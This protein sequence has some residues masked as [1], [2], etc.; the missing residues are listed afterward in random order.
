MRR[1]R[2]QRRVRLRA[3]QPRDVIHHLD[4]RNLPAFA[5]LRSLRHLDLQLAGGEQIRRRHAE[6]RRRHLLG[7]AVAPIAGA[8]LFIALRILTAFAAVAA[9]ADAVHRFGQRAMRFRTQRAHRHG[10][11]KEARPDS[12][13]RLDLVDRDWRLRRE[14][15]QIANRHRRTVVHQRRELRVGVRLLLFDRMVELLHQRRV[16]R[17]VIAVAAEPVEARMRQQIARHARG[18]AVPAHALRGDFLE[19][20][21]AG[22]CRPC[23]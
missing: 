23:R 14:V 12:L 16:P 20:H 2:D 22:D 9:G 1:R 17:V 5:G 21:R 6:A 19:R 10:R 11:G 18:F 8:G 4:G 13:D 15:Q 7:R 3:P